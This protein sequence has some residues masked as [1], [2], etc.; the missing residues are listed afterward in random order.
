MNQE[1][2]RDTAFYR[3]LG[4]L[5]VERFDP[6]MRMSRAVQICSTWRSHFAWHLANALRW[7][8]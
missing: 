7:R 1:P 8:P 2:T 3:R 6:N 4:G 5:I